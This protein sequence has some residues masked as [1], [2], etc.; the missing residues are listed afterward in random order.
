M[1]PARDG[2]ALCLSGDSHTAFFERFLHDCERGVFDDDD[3]LQYHLLLAEVDGTGLGVDYPNDR[4]VGSVMRHRVELAEPLAV[5]LHVRVVRVVVE[6]RGAVGDGV[7]GVARVAKLG[8]VLDELD[9]FAFVDDVNLVG[10]NAQKFCAFCLG[11]FVD[12]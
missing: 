11:I 6:P 10:R 7:R 1:R 8:V 4:H 9:V 5:G 12:F 3:L 2:M